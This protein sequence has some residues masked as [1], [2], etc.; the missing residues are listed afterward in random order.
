MYNTPTKLG[1]LIYQDSREMLLWIEKNWT[2]GWTY[3]FLAVHPILFHW[4]SGC[5]H[6][7][8]LRA[9][10]GTNPSCK[11]N[12]DVLK[13]DIFKIIVVSSITIMMILL[14][15]V[16]PPKNEERCTRS[17][18]KDLVSVDSSC[19]YSMNDC[20]FCCHSCGRNMMMA[21]LISRSQQ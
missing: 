21:K 15:R 11:G 5:P 1:P 16:N 12:N 20:W 3:I 18:S 19:L 9:T 7:P 13:N 10:H 8:Q 2:T 4:N 17:W 14:P 6:T